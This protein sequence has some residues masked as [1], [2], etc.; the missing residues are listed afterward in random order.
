[1]ALYLCHE[2]FVHPE[3]IGR[4]LLPRLARNRPSIRSKHLPRPFACRVQTGPIKRPFVPDLSYRFAP[5]NHIRFVQRCA[6]L[7]QFFIGHSIRDGFFPGAYRARELFRRRHI[8]REIQRA[9]FRL[10][11]Q[12][13]GQF[14]GD[15]DKF[16]M[17]YHVSTPPV[18]ALVPTSGHTSTA[19]PGRASQGSPGTRKCREC[20]CR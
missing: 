4:P 12:L 16:G 13:T 1:M 6:A 2:R 19:A 9:S 3:P 18:E 20:S 10:A 8:R 17:Y 14:A 11:A 5:S 15:R 7:S